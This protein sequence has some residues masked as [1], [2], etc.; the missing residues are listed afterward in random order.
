MI[1]LVGGWW[2]WNNQVKPKLDWVCGTPELKGPDISNDKVTIKFV[3]GSGV[4]LRD[5]IFVSLTGESLDSLYASLE[6]YPIIKIERLFSQSEE[7]LEKEKQQGEEAT[8]K[9]LADL[10]LYYRIVLADENKID[11]F[12][13]SLNI[14]PIVQIAYLTPSPMPLST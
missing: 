7:E 13:D 11:S 10:N 14:L 5:G 3:E 4:R 12:I 9:E 1:I 8:G 6:Q 2:V